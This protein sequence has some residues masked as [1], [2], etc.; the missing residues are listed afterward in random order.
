MEL[1][2]SSGPVNGEIDLGEQT[3][4]IRAW[5][6]AHKPLLVG[7]HGWLDNANSFEP[8]ASHLQADYRVLAIDW[9]GHGWSPRRPGNYPLHWVDYLYDLHRLLNVV[10]A[11]TPVYIVGHSLG[12]IVASAYAA[13]YPERVIALVLIE[14]LT[15]LFEDISYQ[16]SR[17]RKSF[18]QTMEKSRLPRHYCELERAVDSR[19][20]LTGLEPQ[21]CRLIL[22]R[23]IAHDAAGSYWRTDPR[24]RTDSPQRLS[25]AQV[26]QLMQGIA[27]PS[28]LLT[29]TEGY[30]SLAEL[31]PK[32]TPWF[33][34]LT[35]VQLTGNHHLHMENAA[36]VAL[37]IKDFLELPN[38]IGRD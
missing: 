36:K 27:I 31:L 26:E 24:L 21:W 38:C 18:R 11:D 22:Q 37:A 6:D 17:L 13:A 5:G 20:R 14:A 12:G 16:R 4:A 32:V 10:S 23:N 2:Q 19:C 3:V 1:W 8:L 7:L 15:P 29:G 9:P 34:H 30:A 28:L 25:L 35:K 33:R